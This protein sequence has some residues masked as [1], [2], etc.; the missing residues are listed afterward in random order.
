M[1]IKKLATA[2]FDGIM[3]VAWLEQDKLLLASPNETILCSLENSCIKE[4]RR[5]SHAG[6]SFSLSQ[7]R[8]HKCAALQLADGPWNYSLQLVDEDSF[9]GAR[10]EFPL[11]WT[12]Q[13]TANSSLSLLAAF[14]SL[15]VSGRAGYIEPIESF[16]ID[17]KTG[18]R[19]KTGFRAI[20]LYDDLVYFVKDDSLYR[21]QIDR[22]SVMNRLDD[23]LVSDLFSA[24]FVCSDVP[25]DVLGLYR[26]NNC[27]FVATKDGL[28]VASSA[29]CRRFP[30]TSDYFTKVL[31]SGSVFF[32]RDI[33]PNVTIYDSET[34]E[35]S[36]VITS[37]SSRVTGFDVLQ[38]SSQ[39]SPAQNVLAVVAEKGVV[40]CFSW[41][42]T[43]REGHCDSV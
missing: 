38:G 41:D 3:I 22:T 26:S 7:L 24:Q 6:R 33:G 8:G 31:M 43:S 20:A 2:G 39:K 1:Q 13:I 42:C 10:M 34:G 19:I 4:V 23:A 35:N 32:A 15:V 9:I 27:T 36:S 28:F 30:T 5:R 16:L 25:P 14:G 18:N 21:A 29:G 12:N 40:D 17:V 37:S 11:S